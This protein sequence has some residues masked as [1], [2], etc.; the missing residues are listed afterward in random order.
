[1]HD[2]FINI[3]LGRIFPFMLQEEVKLEK[4]ANTLKYAPDAD[5]IYKQNQKKKYK[6]E[7][8]YMN[9]FQL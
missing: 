4:L 3:Q 5:R 2:L 8:Q 9:Y 7:E 6:L 1:M